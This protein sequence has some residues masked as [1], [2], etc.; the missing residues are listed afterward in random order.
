[1]LCLSIPKNANA[2]MN[3]DLVDLRKVDLSTPV[4]NLSLLKVY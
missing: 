4:V 2:N 3:F 1:M